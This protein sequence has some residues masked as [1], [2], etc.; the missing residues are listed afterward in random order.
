MLQ[1]FLLFF[2]AGLV[3]WTLWGKPR[4][5]NIPP[6]PPQY[7]LLGN[8][9]QIIKAHPF[10]YRAYHKLSQQY[11]ELMYVRVG[12]QDQI[13]VSSYKALKDLLDKEEISGRM[14]NGF[15]VDRSHGKELGMIFS[16][17]PAQ[18]DL[19][20][21][22]LRALRDYGFNRSD[23]MEVTVREELKH[24]HG[25]MSNIA[26]K[27]G[28]QYRME[29]F[30]QSSIM[31]ILWVMM[32]GERYDHDDPNLERLLKIN[33]T[34]FQ[35]GN[36]GAGMVVAYPFLRFLFKEWTGYYRIEEGNEMIWGFIR[37]VIQDHR[38]RKEYKNEPTNFIDHFLQE[39]DRA[40][41]KSDLFTE[42]Q[43]IIIC[44]DMFQGGFETTSNTLAY[45]ILYMM[46]NPHVQKKTQEELDK[47]FEKRQ[48]ASVLDKAKVPYTTATMLEILRMSN[49]L[50]VPGPRKATKDYY[51]NGYLIPKGFSVAL[52]TYSVMRDTKIFGED[53]DT[54]RPER[55]IGPD[56]KLNGLEQYIQMSWGAGRRS[57][58][59]DKLAQ[60]TLFMFLTYLLR[61]FSFQKIENKPDPTTE[62]IFGM[63]LSPQ[64]F[65]VIV[66]ER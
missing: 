30:F 59:G 16:S 22:V 35:S 51:Y 65:D 2:V 34:W 63:I 5:K 58:I 1:A 40:G 31:S 50:P 64:P 32:A 9:P 41:G 27:N 43:F 6:G 45:G 66:K 24:F 61:N 25:R 19:K 55:F 54:F 21:Y 33:S 26:K 53:V 14:W 29:R 15:L 39:I 57:C 56:G 42:E 18:K 23:S 52:N 3:V 17:L 46:L 44:Y 38:N 12:M 20:T 36:F 48:I 4:R 8:L 10:G 60:T 28:G 49:I 7:P 11:G 13:V 37:E 47:V 62:P